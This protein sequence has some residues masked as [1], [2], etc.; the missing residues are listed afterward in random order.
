M[1]F[2]K[3]KLTLLGSEEEAFLKAYDNW[4]H[5]E[6]KFLKT[7]ESNFKGYVFYNISL[8]YSQAQTVF[9]LGESFGMW[10]RVLK[11]EI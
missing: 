6:W 5:P 11:D 4:K 10:R 8:P 3:V 1:K 2:I 9:R 7:T